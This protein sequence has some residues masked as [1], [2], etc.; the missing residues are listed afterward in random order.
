[1]SELQR[2]IIRVKRIAKNGGAANWQVTVTGPEGNPLGVSRDMLAVGADEPRRSW[3]IEDILGALSTPEKASQ[4]EEIYNRAVVQRSPRDG[5]LKKLGEFL[6]DTL[7]GQDAWAQIKT[8][9]DNRSERKIELALCFDNAEAVQTLHRLN[10]EMMHAPGP[11]GLLP[12]VKDVAIT[13]LVTPRDAEEGTASYEPPPLESP[14][15]VLF[16]IGADL[17]DD[18]IQPAAEYFSLLRLL[19]DENGAIYDRVLLKASPDKL[20]AE[21]KEFQPHVVH[22][23]CHGSFDGDKGGCLELETDD[24]TISKKQYCGQLLDY[25]GA[26]DNYPL[27]VVLTACHSGTA[28]AAVGA[29]QMGPLAAELVAGG[30]PVVVGMGGRVSDVACRLFTRRF[31]AALVAGLPLVQAT[32]QGRWAAFLGDQPDSVDWAFPTLFM[33]DRVTPGYK[34]EMKKGVK[35]RIEAVEKRISL[36]NL[37]EPNNPVFCARHEF[38]DYL[39]ELL[40]D[41]N[42]TV[43]LGIYTEDAQKGIGRTRLLKELAAQAVRDGH[44]PC[45]ITE[46]PDPQ[47]LKTLARLIYN[48]MEE[49]RRKIN[50]DRLENSQL[51][52]LTCNKSVEEISADPQLDEEIADQLDSGE[53]TPTAVRLAVQDHITKFIEKLCDPNEP[54]PVVKVDGGR[55]ILL[56]DDVDQYG[57]SL[58]TQFIA[59]VLDTLGLGT[60]DRP[61]PVI[62]T[63]RYL[64]P[65]DPV[66]DGYNTGGKSKVGLKLRPL[67]P[68]R[69]KIENE[70]GDLVE[71]YEDY[72]AYKRIFLHGY[73]N[74]P[75]PVAFQDDV[76]RPK[77]KELA[78]QWKQYLRDDFAGMPNQFENP[79]LIRVLLRHGIIEGFMV[80]AMDKHLL[81]LLLG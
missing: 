52:L 15:C 48:T 77:Q 20:K 69:A 18:R 79:S 58:A 11:E 70:T 36:L 51:R 42:D 50:L 24:A 75:T 73:Q 80:K 61:A 49:V 56:F 74:I 21:I 35:E 62:F 76:R 8:E 39:R 54:D 9:A 4:L 53:I 63:Y 46:I 59:Q 78:D 29:A 34:V 19:H 7:I 27:V 25:L 41:R 17:N 44:I 64:V 16:V 26:G 14:P 5:D 1:M 55:V 65:K 38:F 45:L 71:S 72:L 37:R 13:R 23:I 12:L 68:F 67:E 3:D 57:E 6:F 10:W 47:D 60:P 22:F 43:I 31:G 33:D 2:F 66:I 32:A 40:S 28:G 81:E 30:V